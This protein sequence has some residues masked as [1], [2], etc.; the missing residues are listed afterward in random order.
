MSE[1]LNKV[2]GDTPGRLAI[3][4]I[5]VSIIV[6]YVMKLFGWYPIDIF[7]G[8]RNFFVELWQTGFEALGAV[9][10]YFLLG[11]AVVIPIFILIRVMSYRR[12]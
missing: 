7:R 4:L 2:L 10:D 1:Q 8:I 9:G 5:V 3:K 11:A 12:T 6:G